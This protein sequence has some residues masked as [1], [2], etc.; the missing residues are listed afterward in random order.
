MKS[1]IDLIN[2]YWS[3]MSL[4]PAPAS[5]TALYSLLLQQCN[6]RR[7][8]NPFEL[9]TS[10]VEYLLG[11]NR[12]TISEA[13]RRLEA[14]GLIRYV[15]G[16]R[17]RSPTYLICGAEITDAALS[18][19]FSPEQ[20]AGISDNASDKQALSN[21]VKDKPNTTSD[22][23]PDISP[24]TVPDTTPDNN[25]RYKN[26]DKDKNINKTRDQIH[27]IFG[28]DDFDRWK[29][30]VCGR[31]K[32]PRENLSRLAAQFAEE[33]ACRGWT[34]G[35]AEKSTRSLFTTWLERRVSKQKSNNFNPQQY[36]TNNTW[37]RPQGLAARMPHTPRH[38]LIE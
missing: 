37:Y 21:A 12:D 34:I 18:T 4:K 5:G 23:V 35:P 13:R 3:S 2:A 1:Y 26:K 19:R 31:F 24:D 6:I 30:A 22:T 17:N 36:G 38:G 33:A 15:R 27:S 32:I 20:L 8:S 11:Y 9:P 7:W 28:E 14:R 25:I 10:L 29:D 16:T